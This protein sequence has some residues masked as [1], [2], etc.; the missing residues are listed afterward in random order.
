MHTALLIAEWSVKSMKSLDLRCIPEPDSYPYQWHAVPWR[1]AE[2]NLGK[3]HMEIVFFFTWKPLWSLARNRTISRDQHIY[4]PLHLYH[5][6][7]WDLRSGHAFFCR[8]IL[9]D[10]RP[11]PR[12]CRKVQGIMDPVGLFAMGFSGISDF[13]WSFAV[14]SR[15]IIDLSL[16][17]TNRSA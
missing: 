15:G 6:I 3:L 14:G 1:P 8:E 12:V 13:T 2:R 17:A 4:L 16:G 10:P 7:Q 5:E 9:S 11:S